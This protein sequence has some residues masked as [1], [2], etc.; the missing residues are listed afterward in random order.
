MTHWELINEE[1]A[2][3]FTIR[4]YAAPEDASPRDHFALDTETE[5]EIFR[6]ID[7]GTLAW[8]MAKVT[9]SKAD[10]ELAA[11]YLGCCCYEFVIDFVSDNDYYFDMKAR[12][13]D[14]AKQTIHILSNEAA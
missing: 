13:I 11:D 4:F 9:A 6:K 5:A 3:G 10:V 12:V 1:H 7:N 8:F 2:D 14:E